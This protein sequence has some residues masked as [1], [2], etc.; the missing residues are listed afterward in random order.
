MSTLPAADLVAWLLTEGRLLPHLQEVVA[1]LCGRLNELGFE[2]GRVALQTRTLHPD[3]QVKNYVFTPHTDQ[4]L[5]GAAQRVGEVVLHSFETGT[6]SEVSRGFGSF[7]SEAFRHSPVWP[8]SQGEPEVRFCIEPQPAS[9]PFAVLE[10]L[11]ERRCTDYVGFALVSVD[12]ARSAVSLAT[13][14]AG[15]FT[16][17]DLS[18]LRAIMPVLSL[19]V[20]VH[21]E[22]QVTRS[23]LRTYLGHQPGERVLAGRIRRGDVESLEAAIWFSDIRGF[24][25]RSAELDATALVHWLNAYFGAIAPAIEREGGEILKFIGDA[26]LAVFPLTP[27]RSPAETCAAALRAARAAN[28]ALDALNQQVAEPYG[29]GIALHWGQVQYGNIGAERRLDFTVIGPA[30]NLA[31][32]VEALCGRLGQRTLATAAL[33]S[34]AGEALEAAGSFQLKGIAEPQLIYVVG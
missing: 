16:E 30:V 5:I 4:V 17:A 27:E 21:T 23:L 3:V 1:G 8:L 15:G 7:E 22:R 34:L 12:G 2:L 25:V 18:L 14:K 31:S 32:R 26:I 11:R 28:A 10:D 19:C 24:T 6:V 13:R 20:E 9:L 33:A 29:H